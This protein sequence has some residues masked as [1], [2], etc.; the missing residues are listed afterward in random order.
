MFIT[1]CIDKQCIRPLKFFFG[2]L[3]GNNCLVHNA[4]Y[5]ES[6]YCR[7]VGMFFASWLAAR[8]VTRINK[9]A[10]SNLLESLKIRA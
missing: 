5:P 3:S 7:L 1:T 2:G 9:T 10:N 4:K 6:L 8:F